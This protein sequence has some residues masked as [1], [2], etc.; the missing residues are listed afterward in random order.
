MQ[1]YKAGR[2]DVAPVRQARTTQELA[3]MGGES[4]AEDLLALKQQF[5]QLE[6]EYVSQS[7]VLLCVR[8]SLT[9]IGHLCTQLALL[10]Y[11]LWSC[12]ASRQSAQVARQPL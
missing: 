10:L 11:A 9:V 6:V 1:A 8:V 12:P 4:A 2:P 3:S 5:N 7:C